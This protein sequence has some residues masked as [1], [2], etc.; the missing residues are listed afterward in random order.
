M[1][2]VE[3]DLKSEKDNSSA[4]QREIQVLNSKLELGQRDVELRNL[5]SKLRDIFTHFDF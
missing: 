2:S 5:E 1:R 3:A 4:L